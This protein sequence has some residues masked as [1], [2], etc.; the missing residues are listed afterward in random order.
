M[1]TKIIVLEVTV[2]AQYSSRQAAKVTQGYSEAVTG[3]LLNPY[4]LG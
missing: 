2:P 3:I 4:Q 1:Y